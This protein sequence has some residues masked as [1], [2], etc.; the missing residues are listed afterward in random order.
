MPEVFFAHSVAR[1]SAIKKAAYRL[2]AICDIDIHPQD[3]GVRCTLKPTADSATENVVA[4]F[5][6]T[7]LDYE[8]REE[9]AEKTAPFRDALLAITFAPLAG[10]EG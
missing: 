2:S 10:K 4:I 7:V 9:I 5:R 6:A 3:G 8:L 1:I